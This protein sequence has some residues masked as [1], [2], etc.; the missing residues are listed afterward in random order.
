VVFR[1]ME[2]QLKDV[3]G[4]DNGG[5]WAWSEKRR[6]AETEDKPSGLQQPQGVAIRSAWLMGRHLAASRGRDT[7]FV[8]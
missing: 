1:A 2:N 8:F 3:W 6:H 7:E 4:L 5:G